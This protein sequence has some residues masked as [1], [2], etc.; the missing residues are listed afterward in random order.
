VANNEDTYFIFNTSKEAIDSKFKNAV[1]QSNLA[2]F[3][4]YSS[5]DIPTSY[6]EDDNFSNLTEDSYQAVKNLWERRMN[7]IQKLV[8]TGNVSKIAFPESGFGD[9]ELMPRELFVYLSK[10]LKEE[11]GY[12]NPGSTMG[13]EVIGTKG[14]KQAITDEDI[15][16]QFDLEEDPFTCK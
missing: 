6:E 2:N 8:E 10:R 4:E 11:F 7:Q 3:A 1:G 9:A 5:L 14:K 12:I 13:R 15:R 16:I